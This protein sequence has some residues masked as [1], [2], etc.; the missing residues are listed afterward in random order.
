MAA[1]GTRAL[2]LLCAGLACAPSREPAPRVE[3]SRAALADVEAAAIGHQYDCPLPP[4]SDRVLGNIG[5][6]FGGDELEWAFA[7]LLAEKSCVAPN[8]YVIFYVS[9][10]NFPLDGVA[11]GTGAAA[12]QAWLDYWSMQ[13]RRYSSLGYQIW[14]HPMPFIVS[15]GPSCN[16]C[17]V[18]GL[19]ALTLA[20]MDLSAGQVPDVFSCRDGR[21]T[22]LA[23]IYD[24][25]SSALGV[26]F[27]Q[28]LHAFFGSNPAVTKLSVVPPS[29][30]G[31]YGFPFGVPTAWWNGSDNVGDCYL[32]G[33]PEARAL[34][35]SDPPS[36][37]QYNDQ[38]TA[39][40]DALETQAAATFPGKKLAMYLGYG[41]DSNPRDGFSYPAAVADAVSRGMDVHSSHGEGLDAA[42]TPLSR[43][44]LNL[45]AGHPFTMEDVGNIGEYKGLKNAAHAAKY[46]MTGLLRYS[47]Y[48]HLYETHLDYSQGLPP[49]TALVTTKGI[50][51][52]DAAGLGALRTT[53]LNQGFLD[54]PQPGATVNGD[55]TNGIGGWAY[56]DPPYGDHQRYGVNIYA[57]PLIAM[58]DA[59]CSPPAGY[60]GDC[61]CDGTCGAHHYHSRYMRL[62]ATSTTTS[63][64][65]A[66]LGDT[67]RW[68]ALWKP[69]LASG[70]VVVRVF[71]VNG[72]SEIVAEQPGS[73][74]I[75]NIDSRVSG[76]ASFTRVQAPTLEPCRRDLRAFGTAKDRNAPGAA[77]QIVILDEYRGLVLAT[78]Q[79]DTAGN[80]DTT[81]TVPTP[82]PDPTR[83][84]VPRAY[85]WMDNDGDGTNELVGLPG[86]LAPVAG[87]PTSDNFFDAFANCGWRDGVACDDGKPCTYADAYSS[88]VCTGTAISCV[89]DSTTCGAQRACNG[90]AACT[91]SYAAATVACDDGDACTGGDHCDGMGACVGSPL[92]CADAGAGG[93]AGGGG[94][95]TGGS[96]AGG[97]S[98]GGGSAGGGSAGG[99][100]AGGGSAGGAGGSAGGRA[101]G[102]A[103]GG[104]SVTGGC[105]CAGTASDLYLPVL[106]VLFLLRRTRSFDRRSPI[107][108]T[109]A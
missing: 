39:F 82:G 87:Y 83:H 36:S 98:A 78:P 27:Y 65:A 33:D 95:G 62:V 11:S 86:Q 81:F 32:T 4:R 68:G 28:G 46:G 45:P 41:S 106:T 57:G 97:G 58:N 1:P 73:P 60:E 17:E 3:V 80:F 24:S 22:V 59:T 9:T 90:T 67:S 70:P 77:L 94:A 54:A 18:A 7:Q 42:D 89:S 71:L 23:S 102:S 108:R 49:S 6:V 63:E 64:R 35:A 50:Y 79:T 72:S 66:G 5:Y 10:V 19:R 92:T 37:A 13:L 38:L 47:L 12:K 55:A 52:D 103:G 93:G 100:S 101:G 16:G 21:K 15:N 69:N 84:V 61:S 44:V 43:I 105:G 14:L 8:R 99:G 56:F 104:G 85:V 91:V 25:R 40:Y 109:S 30:F 29:D 34:I 31:E 76:Q 107:R 88:Q 53:Q 74:V 51:L 26:R 96:G 48:D 75:V 20:D 2:L